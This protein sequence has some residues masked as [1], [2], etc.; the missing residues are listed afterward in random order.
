MLLVFGSR[1]PKNDPHGTDRYAL[2]VRDVLDRVLDATPPTVLL[3]GGA[4]GPDLWARHLACRADRVSAGWTNRS[5]NVTDEEWAKIGP[6]AGPQRNA[7]MAQILRTQGGTW[8]RRAV[9][10]WDGTSPG[11]RSMIRELYRVGVPPWVFPIGDDWRVSWPT[12]WREVEFRQG[13]AP[14]RL[15]VAGSNVDN[16]RVVLSPYADLLGLRW[17]VVYRNKSE[18]GWALVSIQPYDGWPQ[19]GAP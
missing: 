10:F 11:T 3:E 9:G 18:A 6:A 13:T 17:P 15:V 4:K 7:R 14:I 2:G 19:R 1:P 5:E 8:N 16:A 12:A